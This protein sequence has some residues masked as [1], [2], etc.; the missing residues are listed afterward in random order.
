[1]KRIEAI[2]RPELLEEMKNALRNAKVD[3]MT[4]YEVSGCGNQ[5]GWTTKVRGNTVRL[6]TLPKVYFMIVVS[7]Q[8]KDEII[9]LIIKTAR[10]GNVGDGK[11][12]VT[13]VEDCI[14][15]RT[16][17]HGEKAL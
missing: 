14:R 6:N 3:G 15:I 10:T 16:G 13:D 7:D 17:E 4:I 11:V 12:F 5:Y 8:R 2:I 1:M 9:D